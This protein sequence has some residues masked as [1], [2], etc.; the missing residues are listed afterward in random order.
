MKTKKTLF[1]VALTLMLL[2]GLIATG[3]AIAAPGPIHS[4]HVAGTMDYISWTGPAPPTA[5]DAHGNYLW[6]DQVVTWLCRGDLEGTYVM[7]VT[8]SWSDSDPPGYYAIKGW[9]KFTGE[10]RGR[11][12]GWVAVVSGQGQLDFAGDFSGSDSWVSCLVGFTGP[13]SPLTGRLIMETRFGHPDG[14]YS[15]YKVTL[16]S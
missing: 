2:V 13:R 9:A 15:R 3:T 16:I 1:L 10:F 7:T 4:T 6:S 11:K 12:T 8:Y 14:D 5:P